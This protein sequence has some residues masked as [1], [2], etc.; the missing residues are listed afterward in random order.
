MC[1]RGKIYLY[2]ATLFWAGGAINSYTGLSFSISGSQDFA[3]LYSSVNQSIKPYLNSSFS[4][5]A[6]KNGPEPIL[7]NSVTGSIDW[8]VKHAISVNTYLSYLVPRNNYYNTSGGIDIG[9]TILHTKVYLFDGSISLSR[10]T[11]IQ[12]YQSSRTQSG[13]TIIRNSTSVGFALS[14]KLPSESTLSVQITKYLYDYDQNDFADKIMSIWFDSIG[15]AGD[16]GDSRILTLQVEAFS[17]TDYSASFS[18][19]QKFSQ[20]LTWSMSKT[21]SKLHNNPVF[22]HS[23]G[24]Q[25]SYNWQ[26]ITLTMGINYYFGFFK[27]EEQEYLRSDNI[28]LSLNA[29]TFFD[30]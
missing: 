21:I 23:V 29:Y 5:S 20:N 30:W 10:S 19:R 28:S 26:Q 18:F 17:A 22:S 15:A 6:S 27:V 24:N 8:Q 3:S 16:N 12:D 7:I 11:S 25:L 4:L 2:M 1:Y 14:G 9:F 13:N